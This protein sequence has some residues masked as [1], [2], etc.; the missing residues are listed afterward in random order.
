MLASSIG[1]ILIASGLITAGGAV[2]ALLFPYLFLRPGFN[3]E[4]PA[5]S[6]VF[7]VRHWGVLIL[8]VGVLIV[9][10]AHA[11]IVRTPVLVTAAIEKFAMGLL[12]SWI[13][14]RKQEYFNI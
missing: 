2:A 10:S 4:S 12:D 7:F 14:D 1:W 13:E 11:P 6:A 3:V 9:Y 8:A 5:S